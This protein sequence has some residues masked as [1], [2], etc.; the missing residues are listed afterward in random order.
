MKKILSITLIV[1]LILTSFVS[2]GAEPSDYTYTKEPVSP[3]FEVGQVISDALQERLDTLSAET[4]VV[5]GNVNTTVPVYVWLTDIDQNAVLTA[6][7]EAESI[8]IEA[9]L[10][11]S[12]E[13]SAE[14]MQMD[15]KIQL[16]ESQMS[17]N[18]IQL[19]GEEIA[20]LN[21]ITD[22]R[23]IANPTEYSRTLKELATKKLLL[24][25]QIEQVDEF[26]AAKRAISVA[27]YEDRIDT[28]ILDNQI[29]EEDIIFRSRYAPMVIVNMPINDVT[30][31]A[32]ENDV[33]YMDLFKEMT[34]VTEN[35]SYQ[36]SNYYLDD[37]VSLV[38]GDNVK[39]AGY[40]G[41]GVKVG[42]I[43]GTNV[44]TNRT[45]A[46]V[47]VL[48]N[49]GVSTTLSMHSCAVAE[50]IGGDDGFA[51]SCQIYSTAMNENA[52][53]YYSGI[54]LLLDYNVNIINM[55]AQCTN[56]VSTVTLWTE[57][58]VN[59]HNVCFVKSAGNDEQYHLISAPGDAYN[60][61][62]VG[63]YVFLDEDENTM[64]P[65]SYNE[66]EGNMEKP[67][68][69]ALAK[70]SVIAETRRGT[71]FSAPQ[72]TGVLAQL[73]SANANLRYRPSL[74]KAIICAGAWH[75][76]DSDNYGT[77][78][79]QDFSE[80]EGAGILNAWASYSVLANSRYYYP[81]GGTTSFPITRTFTVT[82]S[83]EVIRVA[84]SWERSLSISGTHENTT[85]SVSNA[86]LSDLD[87][88]VKGANGTTR[89]S[90]SSTN[91]VELV[92][93]DPADYGYGTYTITIRRYSGSGTEWMSVAW[94]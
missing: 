57:H 12:S 93:I 13:L 71:S 90:N 66:V 75:K 69:I 27:E 56:A 89:I 77:T 61:I 3:I 94:Y 68:V 21:K 6:A 49:S 51:P 87:L 28:Y 35:E 84:L 2:V 55:S 53:T 78:A 26:I 20:T 31:M 30:A 83:D 50:I 10:E 11:E 38:D 82:S 73:N 48:T 54:E 79:V 36:T 88:I 7:E 70:F 85:P 67:D 44:N 9:F 34:F 62:T 8:D 41:S 81:A 52:T 60:A 39:I 23:N 92:E 16:Y 17:A 19:S 24:E 63:G 22:G 15:A 37:V 80:E 18:A 4:Q 65:F 72:V 76:V 64:L 1:V 14:V 29:N 5:T 74:A 86:S 40:V 25:D 91:N 59:Q 32:E 58:I 45:T 33:V 42:M 47:T 46:A 43:E